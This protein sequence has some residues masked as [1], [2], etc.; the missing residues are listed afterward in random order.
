MGAGGNENMSRD[1]NPATIEQTSIILEQMKESI[2]KLKTKNGKGTGFF[3]SIPQ[4]DKTV[5]VLITNN[6]ILDQ[7]ILNEN[8]IINLTLNNDKED[9]SLD[10]CETRKIYMNKEYNV[11]IIEVI[12][13]T[14]GISK[15]LEI[16]EELLKD[17]F[18]LSNESIYILQ[19]SKLKKEQTAS[20]SY[21]MLKEIDDFDLINYCSI[22]SG[23]IGG[24]ILKLSNNK[25]IGMH[26]E[27]SSRNNYNK[28]TLLKYAIEDFLEGKDLVEI[29]NKEIVK[30][31]GLNE[32]N[33]QLKIGKDDLNKEIYFL[34]NTN[35]YD[36][37]LV[38]HFHDYLKE[39]KE[40][41]VEMSINDVQQPYQKFSTFTEEGTYTIKLK[42]QNRIR[43]CSYMFCNCVNIINIDFSNFD[44]RSITNMSRMFYNCENLTEI[45]FSTFNT[46]KVT[47][48][49]SMFEQCYKLKS[50][51][52]S[53]FDTESVTNISRMFYGC[54]NL[55]N[56][57]LSSFDDDNIEE[58]KGMLIGCNSLKEVK[59]TKNFYDRIQFEMPSD[60]VE[61]VLV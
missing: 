36:E 54:K 13:K 37:N 12:R 42:F 45:D 6:H 50:A 4:G 56:L 52:L 48:M 40:S 15:F 21:G 10:M 1:T 20:V 41:N 47:N 24:P 34:D 49:F 60:K 3:C 11:T 38:K 44:T 2:C 18:E 32:I 39:L 29:K 17:D 61:F 46:S 35:I 59:I 7:K 51:D 16:D 19:Y 43:D 28:G 9:V 23:A 27:S 25:V 22:R 30:S 57:D 55:E 5:D 53:T 58:I 14:D 26:R 31:S 8:S 33:I